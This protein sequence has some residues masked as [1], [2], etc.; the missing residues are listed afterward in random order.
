MNLAALPV[1]FVQANLMIARARPDRPALPPPA[2]RPRGRTVIKEVVS[3]GRSR[4]DVKS[5]ITGVGR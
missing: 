1:R 2:A 5:S 4:V 3:S